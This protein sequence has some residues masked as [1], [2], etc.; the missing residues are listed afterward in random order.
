MSYSTLQA[1][2]CISTWFTAS[3]LWPRGFWSVILMVIYLCC[4]NFNTCKETAVEWEE[5]NKWRLGLKS[6]KGHWS[7]CEWDGT[8]YLAFPLQVSE[9]HLVALFY[10]R[11]RVQP[12]VLFLQDPV[13]ACKFIRNRSQPGLRENPLTGCLQLPRTDIPLSLELLYV[14][15]HQIHTHSLYR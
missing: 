8:S 7:V 4:K 9:L 11:G 3:L 5:F 10:R 15:P 14:C 1:F 6:H 2:E 12:L 13:Q